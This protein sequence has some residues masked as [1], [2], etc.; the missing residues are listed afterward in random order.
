[1]GLPLIVYFHGYD[2]FHKGILERCAPQYAALFREAA[3]I[4]VVSERMLRRLRELGAPAGKLLHLP[5]FMDLDLFRYSTG[6][7]VPYRFL[8]V[9]RFAETKSP[10]LTILAFEKVVRVIPEATLIMIGR[11]GGGELFEACL[12]LIRALGLEGRVQLRG[13][14]PHRAVAEEM[15]LAHVFV[16]HS[17]TTPENGDMEGKP[18]AVMEAM[19][20][21]LAVVATR[22]SGIDELIQHGVT[23]LLVPEYN[24]EAMAEAM[25]RVARDDSMALRLGRAA[26]EAIHTHPL[27]SRHIQILQETIHECLSGV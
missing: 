25:L 9:G 27:I 1:L 8:A 12:I 21:G 20:S 15:R 4:I 18:V 23:G 3:K 2:A 16:Q 6:N 13:I 19:A 22:H 11:D 14:L 10:H 17:V 7:R 5:A 26:S 24:V